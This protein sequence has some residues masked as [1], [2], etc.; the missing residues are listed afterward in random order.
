M[1]IRNLFLQRFV[2]LFVAWFYESH[3]IFSVGSVVIPIGKS[4][5]IAQIHDMLHILRTDY[6]LFGQ[7]L[8]IQILIDIVSII[9]YNT[10]SV[11]QL[12]HSSLNL[13]RVYTGFMKSIQIPN[14][15]H[16]LEAQDIGILPA[17]FSIC[18]QHGVRQSAWLCTAPSVPTSASKHAAEQALTGI[19]VTQSSVHERLQFHAC[20]LVNT[21]HLRKRHLSGQH[22]ALGSQLL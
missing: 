7:I 18:I 15:T 2:L 14:S 20:L 3:H 6:E 16:I 17:F 1:S 19:T 10:G 8:L 21:A 11:R 5:T 12:L 9:R 13:K 22:N 4:A